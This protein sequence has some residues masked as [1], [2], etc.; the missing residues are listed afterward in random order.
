MTQLH[1]AFKQ[2]N[3]ESFHLIISDI[4]N[5]VVDI[6][7]WM[8]ANIHVLQLNMKNKTRKL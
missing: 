4:Q 5:C 1:M 3:T 8:T 6:K 7:S 2:N